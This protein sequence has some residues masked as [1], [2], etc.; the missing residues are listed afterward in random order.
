MSVVVGVAVS[1][2][3]GSMWGWPGEGNN[4]AKVSSLHENWNQGVESGEPVISSAA[5]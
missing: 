1:A 5:A 4:T 2:G 3:V